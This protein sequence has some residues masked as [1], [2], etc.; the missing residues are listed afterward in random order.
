MSHDLKRGLKKELRVA[1]IIVCF[2]PE[3]GPGMSKEM[4]SLASVPSDS[5]PFTF[6][7][8]GR[9]MFQK[10]ARLKSYTGIKNASSL[11]QVWHSNN[12]VMGAET[13]LATHS[14]ESTTTFIS[15]LKNTIMFFLKLPS[16]LFS[17]FFHFQG[18][19]TER[20]KY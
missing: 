12:C 17:L 5:S 19:S 10:N 14:H 7:R 18:L 2:K 3:R 9:I 4:L 6:Q 15:E 11:P 13:R 1:A 20:K 16:Y 8:A